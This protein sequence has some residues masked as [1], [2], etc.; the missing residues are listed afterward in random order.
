MSRGV[1][2]RPVFEG[3]RDVRYFLS[4]LARAVRRGE[5]EV[6]V[7]CVMTTHFHLLVR[8]LTGQLSTAMRRVL[9]EYA[10]YFNRKRKR[11]GS[12][13]KRPFYSRT[14]ATM[15]YRRMVVAYIDDNPVEAAIVPEPGRY[16]FGS[17]CA[18]QRRRGPPWLARHWVE[19]EVMR[20]AAPYNPALY[21]GPF[22][23]RLSPDLRAWVRNRLEARPTVL[24]DALDDLVGST[25]AGVRDWME[26][27]AHL[28]DGTAPGLRL[29]TAG[30]AE[31]AVAGRRPDWPSW[32]VVRGARRAR[33]DPWH[34]LL[35]GL[36]CDACQ[37]TQEAAAR[38]LSIPRTTLRARLV[39][40]RDVMASYPVYADRWAQLAHEALAGFREL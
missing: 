36:L 32:E 2:R 21:P 26:R 30:A 7:F 5:I 29:A 33:I 11:D 17:A 13:F 40:H 39:A 19:I 28:A 27:K 18:Y 1:A 12:L 22:P 34:L 35:P 16:P 14:V 15:A 6:H 20:G 3:R 8:S 10:R 24:P 37:L 38:R 31:R 23:R 9:G 4:R 25:P